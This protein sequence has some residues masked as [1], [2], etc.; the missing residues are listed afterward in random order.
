MEWR[1]APELERMVVVVPAL[2][3]RKNRHPPVVAAARICTAMSHILRFKGQHDTKI[4]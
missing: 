2:T 3:E 4:C 1:R